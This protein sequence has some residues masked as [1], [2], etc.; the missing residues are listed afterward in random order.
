M[1]DNAALASR[2]ERQGSGAAPRGLERLGSQLRTLEGSGGA[3][4][5]LER[6]GSQSKGLERSGSQPRALERSGSAARALALRGGTAVGAAPGPDE[7]GPGG[8]GG[9]ATRAEARLRDENQRLRAELDALNRTVRIGSGERDYSLVGA[10][11]FCND[12]H[13]RASSCTCDTGAPTGR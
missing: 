13:T 5:G 10:R 6:S 11:P 4:R 1:Q 9:G 3:P 8:P 12:L 7:V 2:L